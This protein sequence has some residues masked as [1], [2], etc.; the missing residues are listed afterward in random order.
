MEN[1]IIRKDTKTK[2]IIKK[3]FFVFSKCALRNKM[4]Q[5]VKNKQNANQQR[6]NRK[7]EKNE[8]Q[9]F[10]TTIQIIKLLRENTMTF[11]VDGTEKAKG[12]KMITNHN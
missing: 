7:E 4:K 5:K 2:L 1:F 8:N 9:R 3:V 12:K 11:V 10:P 6:E